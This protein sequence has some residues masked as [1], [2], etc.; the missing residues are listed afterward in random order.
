MPSAALMVMAFVAASPASFELGGVD[1]QPI[2]GKW[3]GGRGE[4]RGS[5][6]WL[7]SKREFQDAVIELDF[8]VVSGPHQTVG[9]GF[10]CQGVAG[11]ATAGG[12]GVNFTA[13]TF[14]VFEGIANAWKPIDPAWTKFQP[15]PLLKPGKN[16]L[17][18]ECAGKSI[19]ITLNGQLLFA[20]QSPKLTRGPVVLWVE[21]TADVV[22]FSNFRIAAKN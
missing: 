20:F 15:T 11:Q 7:A 13:D 16:A 2:A 1:W 4:V 8:E 17:R 9:F 14:N 10:R 22:K 6:G 21:S 12:L 19:A 18:I 5:G 3:E